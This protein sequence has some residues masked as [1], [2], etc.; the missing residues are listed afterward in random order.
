MKA[1]LLMGLESPSARAERLARLLPIWG[2]VPD[3]RGDGR[4]DRRG[5]HRR[6]ARLRR[7]AWPASAPAALALYGPVERA[8]DAR[9]RCR[10]GCA[11]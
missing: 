6:R 2:R 10:S 4:A 3:A 1:G 11:A 5:D 9:G 7:A 8:P